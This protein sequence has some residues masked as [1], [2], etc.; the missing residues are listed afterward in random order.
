M[1]YGVCLSG[2][3]GQI[4]RQNNARIRHILADSDATVIAA[5][6]NNVQQQSVQECIAETR[7]VIDNAVRKRGDKQVSM[8]TLPYR[9]DQPAPNTKIDTINSFIAD[10]MK[11]CN[12]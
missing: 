6:T 12:K 2:T 9:Y 10:Q 7:Q 4:A 5:G 3:V 1:G 8:S 11:K